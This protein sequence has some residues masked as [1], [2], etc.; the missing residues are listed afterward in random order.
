MPKSRAN[1]GFGVKFMMGNGASPEV[2]AELAEITDLPGFGTTHR[3]DEVTHM[4]SP[5]GWVEHIG[6]GIK[7]GKAFTLNLNF[8]ADDVDQIALFQ[9]RVESGGK[10]NYKIQFTDD[11]DTN[12]TFEAIISDTDIGHPR[13]AKA[14]LSVTVLPSGGY[15][16]DAS[17]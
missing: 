7:E 1:P 4:S 8:V 2:F 15:A 13:D 10:H 3:T 12:V 11:D 9:T 16:W 5:N 6:L 17:T 14:D